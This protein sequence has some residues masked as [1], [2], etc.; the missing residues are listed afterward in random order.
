MLILSRLNRHQQLS[1]RK[2]SD[3]TKGSSSPTG[4]RLV[5]VPP[6]GDWRSGP[7]LRFAATFFLLVFDLTI[8]HFLPV[9]RHSF[10]PFTSG[11]FFFTLEAW[12]VQG[13]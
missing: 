9:P 4:T 10:S 2:Y 3:P 13:S 5:R 6:I 7:W 11:L 8:S 12:P 1:S